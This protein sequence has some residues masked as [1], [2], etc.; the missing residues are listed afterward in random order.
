M[1]SV[2]IGGLCTVAREISD[3]LGTWVCS[4]F[5]SVVESALREID[6]SASVNRSNGAVSFTSGVSSTRGFERGHD[7]LDR[8]VRSVHTI[9]IS[10]FGSSEGGQM[11]PRDF[12]RA[13]IPFVGS[14]SDVRWNPDNTDHLI[15]VVTGRREVI[16]VYLSLAHE[17]IHADQA[18]IGVLT[19]QDRSSSLIERSSE[20]SV[21]APPPGS[22]RSS[23]LDNINNQIRQRCNYARRLEV[24]GEQI[25]FYHIRR[26]ETSPY[27]NIRIISE[28]DL[29]Q[30][31]GEPMRSSP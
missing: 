21:L 14:S 1:L 31:R 30:E 28:N 16:P 7:L 15:P 20:W 12:N 22:P 26:T 23:L 17:L 25:W 8:L 27:V 5:P 11:E 24:N 6:P 9:V 19:A 18:R 3:D 29:R 4:D 13:C 10:R 2:Q